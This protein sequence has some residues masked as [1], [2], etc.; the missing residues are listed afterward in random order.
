MNWYKRWETE[1]DIALD[2]RWFR[3][4]LRW[5]GKMWKS[6]P[7][8][9]WFTAELSL[10][11]TSLAM[12]STLNAFFVPQVFVDYGCRWIWLGNHSEWLCPEESFLLLEGRRVNQCP[13]DDDTESSLTRELLVI[14]LKLAIASAGYSLWLFFGWNIVWSHSIAWLMWC[15]II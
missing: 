11:H 12:R 5:V 14:G 3:I 7:G 4:I 9:M 8:N 1:N 2:L 13:W 6:A 10:E 15:P